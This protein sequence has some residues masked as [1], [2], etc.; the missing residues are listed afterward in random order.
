M[1]PYGRSRDYFYSGHTGYMVFG[2]IYF[3]RMGVPSIMWFNIIGLLIVV[4]VLICTRV[5]YSI[6]IIAGAVM[7][8][9]VVW[10][11]GRLMPWLDAFWSIPY[12][13][14]LYFY[15]KL[16]NSENR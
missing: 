4:F 9:E 1:V 8:A 6:D 15:G 7:S 2:A 3:Y 12:K 16:T 13:L 14:C 5:H 11:V 10:L